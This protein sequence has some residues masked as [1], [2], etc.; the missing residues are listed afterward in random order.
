M[1][2]AMGMTVLIVLDD[3]AP[4]LRSYVANNCRICAT[5]TGQ[6]PAMLNPPEAHKPSHPQEIT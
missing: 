1:A 2:E 3:M 4:D 5:Q 6:A